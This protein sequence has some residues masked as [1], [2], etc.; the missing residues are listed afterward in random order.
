[1]KESDRAFAKVAALREASKEPW[2]KAIV[3][4]SL[5]LSSRLGTAGVSYLEGLL[6]DLHDHPD[7]VTARMNGADLTL[8]EASDL[9]AA[10][11]NSEA[12][13]LE[14]SRDFLHE[15]LMAIKAV[16]EALLKDALGGLL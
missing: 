5:S 15:V 12:D 16:G 14:R 6:A 2:Q 11:Q 8:R 3:D 1:M 9:L 13:Q 10:M 4:L 7:R